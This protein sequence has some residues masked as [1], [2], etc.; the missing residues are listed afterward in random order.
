LEI[1]IIIG[2]N[3]VAEVN[4][5][6]YHYEV[7]SHSL[8]LH[9]QG[10]LR[11]ELSGAAWGR[12]PF[13]SLRCMLICAVYDRTLMRYS[14]V[15]KDMF[16][17]RRG[18]PARTSASRRLPWDWQRWHRRFPEEQVREFIKLDAKRNPSILCR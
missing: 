7:E 17:W 4:G 3:G 8:L 12:M 2:D 9:L 10:D 15:G 11:P 13:M 1:F 14:T 18:M 16:I 6:V 5:G